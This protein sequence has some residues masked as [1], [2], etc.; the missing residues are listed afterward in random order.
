MIFN[1]DRQLIKPTRRGS[2]E[3]SGSVGDSSSASCNTCPTMWTS[4]TNTTV[5]R[6]CEPPSPTPAALGDSSPVLPV[7]CHVSKEME[8]GEDTPAT[9][10]QSLLCEKKGKKEMTHSAKQKTTPYSVRVVP[11][12]R[13]NL[14]SNIPPSSYS[15]QRARQSKQQQQ[16]SR[17]LASSS[18]SSISED[19]P[20]KISIHRD[21]GDALILG[22]EDGESRF[23]KIPTMTRHSLRRPSVIFGKNS[24]GA[25]SRRYVGRSEQRKRLADSNARRQLID[26]SVIA[27]W[28]GR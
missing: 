12:A 4:G 5:K 22:C 6:G 23:K 26:K 20:E 24:L 10:S 2:V 18:L 27:I 7:R 17:C 3:F 9:T 28:M 8:E 11:K 15:C 16:G 21:I 13:N 14:G 1:I 25:S 19:H